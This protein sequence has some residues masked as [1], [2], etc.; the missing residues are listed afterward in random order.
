VAVEEA[1]VD[2]GGLL[3]RPGVDLGPHRVERLVDLARREAVGALEQQVLEE[4]RDPGLLR[5]LVP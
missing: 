1:R 3:A 2:G 5:R 4:V